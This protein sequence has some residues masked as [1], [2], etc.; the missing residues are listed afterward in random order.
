[1]NKWQVH[2]L[3]HPVKFSAGQL[4]A[5]CS[6]KNWAVQVTK[7]IAVCKKPLSGW[8]TDITEKKKK[9]KPMQASNTHEY[10]GRKG[11]KSERS[12]SEKVGGTPLGSDT[13]EAPVSQAG[14]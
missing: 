14:D 3:T 8:E 10:P 12:A 11:Q 6:A 1:M 4:C 7:E 9:C 5:G 2:A 13:E